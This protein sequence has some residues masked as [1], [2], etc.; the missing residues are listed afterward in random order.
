M[1][2]SRPIAILYI[3]QRFV[4]GDDIDDN[5]HYIK[6]H[7][8]F[9]SAEGFDKD[10]WTNDP[11]KALIFD[12]LKGLHRVKDCLEETGV[13]IRALTTVEDRE[14]FG[15]VREDNVQSE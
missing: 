14:E 11:R 13:H 9:Y 6:P 12:S 5:G 1:G 7:I 8:S 4:E 15:L 10:M 2:T 3:L